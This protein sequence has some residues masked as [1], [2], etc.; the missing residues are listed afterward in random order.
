MELLCYMVPAIH[1]ELYPVVLFDGRHRLDQNAYYKL[2]QELIKNNKN[3]IQLYV[4]HKNS[5]KV[6]KPR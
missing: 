6:Q 2:L 1:M 5:L 3:K 4:D